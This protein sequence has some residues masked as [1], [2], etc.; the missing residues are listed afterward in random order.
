MIRCWWMGW[1]GV[2]KCHCTINWYFVNASGSGAHPPHT[3]THC[4]LAASWLIHEECEVTMAEKPVCL[5][6][7]QVAVEETWFYKARIVAGISNSMLSL[8]DSKSFAKGTCSVNEG[9]W[10]AKHSPY[11]RDCGWSKEGIRE[12]QIKEFLCKRRGKPG[13]FKLKNQGSSPSF[14]AVCVMNHKTVILSSVHEFVTR[15]AWVW[16]QTLPH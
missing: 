16:E 12:L 14:T 5:S 15:L 8:K 4:K 6:Y 11:R 10:V 2:G 3:H 13:F 9:S 7:L 1:Q